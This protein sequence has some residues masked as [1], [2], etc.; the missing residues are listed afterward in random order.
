MANLLMYLTSTRSLFLLTTDKHLR[1][2]WL[3]TYIWAQI[4]KLSISKILRMVLT[5][6]GHGFQKIIFRVL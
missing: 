3:A 1:N 6:L 2:S 4:K 5:I